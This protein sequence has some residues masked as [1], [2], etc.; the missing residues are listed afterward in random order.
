GHT[1]SL[2]DGKTIT[3]TISCGVAAAPHPRVKDQEALLRAAGD[4]LYVAKETG[5]NRVVRFDG[6][7][8]NDHTQ[9]KGNDSSDGE[10]PVRQA[11]GSG[12]GNATPGAPAGSK[13]TSE[14]RRAPA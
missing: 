12:A 6:A 8:F 9:S 3:R 2:P 1:F 13:G 7:D 4:A 14:A 5:R 10:R 11:A